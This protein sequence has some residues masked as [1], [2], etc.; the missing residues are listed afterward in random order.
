M[1]VHACMYACVCTACSSGVLNSAQLLPRVIT[2][3]I[4]CPNEEQWEAP[5]RNLL[6]YNCPRDF[7]VPVAFMRLLNAIP[8]LGSV[9]SIGSRKREDQ[10][11]CIV[12]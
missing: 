10:Q 1:H 2:Y 3:A 8:P 7:G 12:V 5:P 11:I 9:F 6:W 4:K